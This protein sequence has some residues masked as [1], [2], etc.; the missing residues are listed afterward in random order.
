[1][2]RIRF[3]AVLAAAA[4]TALLLSGV[5]V[6]APV[7]NPQTPECGVALSRLV[8]ARTE[9][10]A[11]QDAFDALPDTVPNEDLEK[12]EAAVAAAKVALTAALEPTLNY[13]AT[14][15]GNVY[16]GLPG[17]VPP[18]NAAGMTLA[19]LKLVLA[20]ADLGGGARAEVE[21]AIAAYG[22]LAAAEKALADGKTK[23]N[24]ALTSGPVFE[25]LQDALDESDRA[26]DVADRACE[27]QQGDPGAPAP[28]PRVVPNTSSGVDT[29]DGSLA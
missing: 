5:A 9:L 16:S 12:L 22:K 23:P 25:R 21:A 24:P 13:D 29:G 20:D 6:A 17:G 2:S 26:Q 3:G 28:R 4:A 15:P 14:D 10:N 8:D 27:G 11:A 18:A 19:F 7:Q 1:M